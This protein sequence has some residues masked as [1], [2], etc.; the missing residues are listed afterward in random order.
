MFPDRP[1]SRL[2]GQSA[3]RRASRLSARKQIS[4]FL[5]R[6]VLVVLGVALIA[7]RDVEAQGAPP[8][9]RTESVT[10]GTTT[11]TV[12]FE[13]YPMRAGNFTVHT[14]DSSGAFTQVPGGFA[15]T[16]LGRVRQRPGAIAGALLTSTGTLWVRISMEDGTTWT[17]LGGTASRSGTVKPPAWPTSVVGSGGAGT[18]VFAADTGIDSTNNHYLA[19][20]GT[21]EAALD[22]IEFSLLSANLVYLRDA[23]ILH[24][25]GHVVLRRSAAADPYA[26]D[27]GDTGN[28]LTR[29]RSV[30][31]ASGTPMGSTHDIAAVIHSAANGG[32]AYVGTIGTSSRYSSNDSDSNG[33]FSVVW[34]H[35]AGHNWGSGHYEGG[36]NPE[37][38]TIMSN[39]GLSRFS[40]SELAKILNHRNSRA[41]LDNLGSFDLPLPPRANQDA[42]S[43]LRNTPVTIDVLANDS[44]SNGHPLVLHSFD[45]TTA[46]GGTLARSIGTGPGGRDQIIYTP[47]TGLKSG[48]DWF[49]YRIEDASGQQAI[50]HGMLRPRSETIVLAD[51][52]ALDEGAGSSVAANLIRP[53]HPGSHENGV[54]AG[55]P[56]AA[57]GT[58]RGIRFDGT[59]D[60]VAIPAPN[61]NTNT[62]TITT[63]VRRDG[64]QPANAGLVFT[65]SSST[66]A[67]GL[68]LGAASELSYTWGSSTWNSGLVLPD[69]TW[70]LVALSITPTGAVIHLRSPSGLQSA[71]RANSHSSNAFSSTLYLGWDSGNSNRHFR[72][73]MD[74]PRVWTSRLE[75][76]DIES[77]YQQAIDTPDFVLQSPSPG[78]TIPPLAV[79]FAASVSSMPWLVDRI[80]FLGGDSVLGSTQVFPW[81]TTVPA[82][83]SG[84][85]QFSARAVYGDWAYSKETE[86]ISATVL[87][88]PTPVVTV[89]ASMPASKQGPMPGIFRFTRDHPLGALSLAFSITGSAVA[90]TH[91]LPLPGTI[92]FAD[93][94]TVVDLVVTPVAAPPDGI[95]R[96]VIL[97]LADGPDHDLGAASA[98]TLVIDDHVTSVADGAWNAGATWNSGTPAATSGTQDTGTGHAVAHLVTSNNTGSNSQALVA[99]YLRVKNGGILDLARLHATTMQTATYNLPA[100]TLEH[101]GTI[102]FRCS[103]GSSTHRVAANLSF[104]GTSTLR[105]NGGSYQ[106]L[107]ELTGVL[108]GSGSVQIVS[109]SQSGAVSADI[110]Q[111][112]ITRANNPFA[113]NWSVSH[114]ASGDDFAGLRATASNALGSGSVIVGRRSRLINDHATG[115]NS[116]S[117]VTLDGEDARLVLN[118]PWNRP[119]ADLNL[120][121]GSPVVQVGNSASSIGNLSG[122]VGSI[123]GSGSSSSLT[124]NQSVAGVFG[125]SVGSNLTFIK[126]GSA[127]LVLSGSI[128][129]STRLG[130]AN[131]TLSLEGSSLT[132]AS[133]TQTGGSLGLS[134]PAAGTGALALTGNANFSG[135]QIVVRLP[136][137]PP[138]LGIPFTLISFQGTRTGQ[139]PVV[140][141]PPALATVNYGSSSNSAVTVTFYQIHEVSVQPSHPERGET[142]GSGPYISGTSAAITA[143]AF[144]GWR[145]INWSGSGIVDPD[146]PNT[147]VV[148]DSAKTVTAN[149]D[150]P[151]SLWV[152]PASGGLWSEIANW[153]ITPVSMADEWLDF[154]TLDLAADNTT[155]LD[156]N[157]TA[158]GLRF[159]D[160]GAASNNWLAAAVSGTTLTLATTTG[161]PPEIEVLN[162]SATLAV[163]LAGTQGFMKSGD[164][165]LVLNHPASSLTGAISH[166]AGV[167]Q[168]RDGSTNDPAVF[169]SPAGSPISI[170]SGA[171]LDLPR[172]H[173]LTSQSVLWSLPPLAFADNSTLRFRAQTGSNTHH[174]SAAMTVAGTVTINNN[175]G[176]FA[177]DINLAGSLAGSGTIRYLA[178][179][180]SGSTTTTRRLTLTNPANPF[181]GAWFIDYTGSTS[182]DFV[183][184]RSGAPG[185]LGSGPVVIEDRARLST[186]VNN[187]LDSLSAISLSRATSF[188]DLAPHN[189]TNPSATLTVAEGT[190]N[191]GSANVAIASLTQSGGEIRID[192]EADTIARVVVSGDVNFAGGSIRVAISGDPAGKRYE[193]LRYGG[194]LTGQPVIVVDPPGRLVPVVDTGSGSNDAITLVF[195]NGADLVWRGD[196]PLAPGVWDNGQTANW[197]NLGNADTFRAGDQVR[198][199]DTAVSTEPSL[200][201]NL[202]PASVV[203]A[204]ESSPFIL[205]GTGSL[206]GST[207][208]LKSG[209][210]DLTITNGNLHDGGT[211]VNLGQLTLAHA[212]APGSGT[213]AVVHSSAAM[214][215]TRINLNNVTIANPVTLDSN[216]RTGFRGMINT[217]AGNTLSV[218]TG[219]IRILANPGNGGH[220]SSFDGGVLRLTGTIETTGPTP[221]I[222]SGIVEMATTGGN[223]SQLTVG[224]GILRLAAP[225]GVQNG[226]RLNLAASAPA[227][228]DL[229]GH[230]QSLAEIRQVSTHQATVTNNNSTPAELTI[231]GAVDHTFAG[232][233]TDGSG[234]ISIVKRGTSNLTLAGTLSYTGGTTVENG[235]LTLESPSLAD[236]ST[237]HVSGG[238]VLALPH[239]ADDTIDRLFLDGVQLAAGTY[240]SSNTA[241][242]S[243]SGRLVVG[244]GPPPSPYESWLQAAGI[245]P[246]MPE[247]A[248]GASADGSGVPNLIQFAL[249]G[250]PMDPASNGLHR[251]FT[252]DDSGN[253]S[254]V[255]TIAVRT[256]A[257]FDTAFQP[258]ASRD[259]I[260]YT[261]EGSEGL[262]LWSAGVVEIPV[263]N[264]GGSITAPPGY[265]LRSFR[266]AQSPGLSSRG[267]LRVKVE[268][269]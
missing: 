151:R 139:P 27:G 63:W 81:Q 235:T 117:G 128:A 51:R 248:P 265:E 78:A 54:V 17:S 228:L 86:A 114:T 10:D 229:N 206:T 2:R 40:S 137:V 125:G 227:T 156:V 113:G 96:T 260:R 35:E 75:A 164:G 142:S 46:L 115:L 178:T 4:P 241:F 148:V 221:V 109:D 140:F 101:G 25:L 42:A 269:D 262:P 256:G 152:N 53:T 234:G 93:G 43:F 24:R 73:W 97:T 199:D 204:N 138:P 251:V 163:P 135:G 254:L 82:I 20:G 165:T 55:Q 120:A 242:I 250:D 267:F 5:K 155:I 255:L 104:S 264:G 175:G 58:G 111:V 36:G 23:A 29:V 162:R 7:C 19:C 136:T 215:T 143:T 110:R 194:S 249:G 258:R 253:N 116:L 99:G 12:D 184:L 239:G 268:S 171:T 246:E 39:N 98:A 190:A 87:P 243:G 245:D 232:S 16:Y 172:L 160:A 3:R 133:L 224:E 22:R 226:I 263:Q 41:V 134:L 21:P 107:A 233:I 38:D 94:Q 202:A 238:A 181:T 230:P 33:D 185:S 213:L 150:R 130:V 32:L 68:H 217:S 61:Y 92:D 47:P 191:L 131:G 129:P 231:D 26:P 252:R 121:G 9:T 122:T 127:P 59:N 158:G 147:S 244:T 167:L 48:T 196:D 174:V 212:S 126:S 220:F 14:Q 210:G 189:W 105:I 6:S 15:R 166:Q 182:D 100:T 65:R 71:T 102:R 159:A 209:A 77:L 201:E 173:A 52:W 103:T 197:S 223:L 236:G 180:G 188:L 76:A 88:A 192:A 200:A 106:N 44:D 91:Y 222:R 214:T 83:A 187:G 95:N 153:N 119:S 257:T 79:A 157:R 123:N 74:D 176:A 31:N 11:L 266:L 211:T 60:R 64:T 70:C 124:V 145:F 28:L 225:Q 169:T 205:G 146:S 203:F 261:I 161:L 170:G 66:S 84:A 118:Q 90:G 141:D 67:R 108:S 89:N 186:S 177:Q 37:G 1:L 219:P 132:A 179:S 34:R 80:D 195:P 240:S 193:V 149:F 50:G 237:L 13:L 57:T 30:W 112:S 218:L 45:T 72:G 208:V 18:A 183:A 56:G 154:S 144:P 62:L 85:W 49:I 207:G 8:Q 247:A 198:F 69:N 216:A 168:V 259:G